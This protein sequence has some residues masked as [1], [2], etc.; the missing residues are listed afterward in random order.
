MKKLKYFFTFHRNTATL[1]SDTDSLRT[2][3]RTNNG[4]Y[5]YYS[6]TH[7]QHPH[8]HHH[9]HPHRDTLRHRQDVRR[10]IRRRIRP[11]RRGFNSSP[12]NRRN[13]R[14][15][16]K[17]GQRSGDP[18]SI[19]RN[20]E[21]FSGGKGLGRGNEAQKKPKIAH[22]V[23]D[24][25]K[26]RHP[27]SIPRAGE[28]TLRTAKFSIP[29]SECD[30]RSRLRPAEASHR[31]LQRSHRRPRQYDP[32]RTQADASEMSRRIGGERQLHN[33]NNGNNGNN[34][35]NDD[36]GGIHSKLSGKTHRGPH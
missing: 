32:G 29:S 10:R 23:P 3:E 31:E 7:P 1:H 4:Y 8:P 15:R 17:I 26:R 25:G 16:R 19:P 12:R 18:R 9:H 35:N 28:E 6:S 5:Y 13:R 21:L 36:G 2:N 27:T 20:L 34:S 22:G 33:G 30:V 14:N 24:G 11:Q